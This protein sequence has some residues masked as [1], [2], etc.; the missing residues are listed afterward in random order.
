MGHL[1]R[2]PVSILKIDQSFVQDME[3]APNSAVILESTI[4]LAHDLGIKVIAE[5]VENK[6]Q[7]AFLED[8]GCDYVQGY[9]F[10]EALSLK[11]TVQFIK[12]RP[13]P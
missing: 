3:Q 12:E 7:L 6:E 8:K 13:E 1:K 4:K 11:D 5:G 9:Y 2:L 10:S